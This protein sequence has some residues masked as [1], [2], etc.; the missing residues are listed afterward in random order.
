MNKQRSGI[1][2]E[3]GVIFQA[4]VFLRVSVPTP[5]LHA[6]F[7]PHKR[8]ESC[9]IAESCSDLLVVCVFQCVPAQCL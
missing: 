3:K 7:R 2:S 4:N 5:S 9:E 6:Q 1:K 8:Q